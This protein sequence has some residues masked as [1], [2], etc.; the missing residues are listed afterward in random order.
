MTQIRKRGT[1]AI[2]ICSKPFAT[3]ARSQARINEVPDIPLMLIDHP[4]GGMMRSVVEQ[5]IEQAL[6]Q[7]LAQLRRIFGL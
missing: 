3:L 1:P 6:P 4:L 5:R 2:A 7:F